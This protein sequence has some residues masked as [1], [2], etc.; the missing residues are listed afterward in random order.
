MTFEMNVQR[1][2]VVFK[3]RIINSFNEPVHKINRQNCISLLEKES[4]RKRKTTQLYTHILG[5][6]SLKRKTTFEYYY[7]RFRDLFG[8]SVSLIVKT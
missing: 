7:L 4:Q 2:F 8:N 3:N 5:I 6:K 1:L